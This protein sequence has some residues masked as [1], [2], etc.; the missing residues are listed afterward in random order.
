MPNNPLKPFIKE[1][2]ER[3]KTVKYDAALIRDRQRSI[4]NG[5]TEFEETE[6]GK[7]DRSS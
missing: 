4:Q 6:P 7:P 1:M 3:L 2:A 5:N